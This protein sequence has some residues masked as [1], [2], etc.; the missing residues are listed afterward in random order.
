[1]KEQAAASGQRCTEMV[2]WEKSVG[3][4]SMEYAY[5]YPP[6][7]PLIVPG[8]KVSKEASDMLQWYKG[9]GFAVEGPARD[10]YIEVWMQK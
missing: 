8:E 3:C 4:I 7:S 5:L 6:G 10:R 9:M 1:M 2:P